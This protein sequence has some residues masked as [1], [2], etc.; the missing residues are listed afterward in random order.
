MGLDPQIAWLGTGQAP[1]TGAKGKS[2][3]LKASSG[4][5]GQFWMR[6]QQSFLETLPK[7][8]RG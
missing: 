3:S 4:A 7:V 6:L 2:T 1:Q 8:I 5:G